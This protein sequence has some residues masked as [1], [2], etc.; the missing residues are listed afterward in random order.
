MKVSLRASPP[1]A[2]TSPLASPTATS[3]LGV[4]QHLSKP[5][6]SKP[7]AIA[8]LLFGQRLFPHTPHGRGGLGTLYSNPSSLPAG[9]G[10]AVAFT[11]NG[12]A[13]AVSHANSPYITVY[14]WSTSGFG[15]KY[16]N[17]ASLPDEVRFSHGVAFNSYGDQLLVG[18]WTGSYVAAYP[19]STSGFGTKYANPSTSSGG[20]TQALAFHP[21]ANAVAICPPLTYI[22]VYNF[23]ASGFGTKFSNP[24]SPLG[25][26]PRGVTWNPAG[27]VI[28]IGTEG[29]PCLHAYAWSGGFGTKYSDPVGLP[30]LISGRAV[31]FNQAGNTLAFSHSGSSGNPPI[32]VYPW[33]G[34]GFGTRYTNPASFPSQTG[35]SAAF[36]I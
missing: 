14:P 23:S 10:Y 19:W 20:S 24:S 22:N 27:D 15:T 3:P 31:A 16:S 11:P 26:I 8:E 7:P 1:A 34:S 25:S 4:V 13:L 35:L 29:S 28:V 6:F 36:S 2:D 17:P 18:T 33:S 9:A 32:A 21:S 30:S 5:V 12:D